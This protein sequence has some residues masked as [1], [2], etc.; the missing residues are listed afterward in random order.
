MKARLYVEHWTLVAKNVSEVKKHEL[1]N[2]DFESI[3][4]LEGKKRL[5][6]LLEGEAWST[7]EEAAYNRLRRQRNK[8]MH[9]FDP[10]LLK[11]EKRTAIFQLQG[12]RH[13]AKRLNSWESH[14]C[15]I[16]D[17]KRRVAALDKKISRRTDFYPAIFLELEDDLAKMAAK[18]LVD[19]CPTCDQR[20]ALGSKGTPE[21]L[22]RLSCLVCDEV[23]IRLFLPCRHC[24]KP[25]TRQEG[26]AA[27]CRWCKKANVYDIEEVR[28][29]FKN[30]P[31]AWCGRC[32]YTPCPSVVDTELGAF[33]WACQAHHGEFAIGHCEWCN[34]RVTGRI[35]DRF[36]PGC[37]R[38][39]YYICYD[40]GGELAPTFLVPFD[41]RE[42]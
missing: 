12:W 37:T 5:G 17:F 31:A 15:D 4:L 14:F 26:Q 27:R 28:E 36:K 16:A 41:E 13:L 42:N 40:D 23:H 2:G 19:F 10:S 24:Q 22:F 7:R 39:A 25:S 9:F 8:L 11:E 20:S 38:C 30:L 3:N 29:R 1:L 32:G 21:G 33:C 35:G 18:Q 34:S 6:N